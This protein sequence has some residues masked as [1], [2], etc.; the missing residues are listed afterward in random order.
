MDPDAPQGDVPVIPTEAPGDDAPALTPPVAPP[1]TPDD[2]P[3]VAATPTESAQQQL[4]PVDPLPLP[5]SATPVTP[6]T[7]APIAAPAVPFDPH[8]AE[9]IYFLKTVLGPKSAASLHARTNSR[10][11]RIMELAREKGTVDRTAVRLLLR[12][13]ATTA[14]SYLNALLA[15]GRLTRHHTQRDTLYKVAG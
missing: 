11:E 12:V 4:P 15:S 6:P 2:A 10:L 7:P 13:S 8:S 9:E 5:D 14:T 3:S 1:E